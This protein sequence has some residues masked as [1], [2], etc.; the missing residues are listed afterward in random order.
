MER[1]KAAETRFKHMKDQFIE[2]AGV[3]G[4]RQQSNEDKGS[5]SK[6]SSE[7]KPKPKTAP[8]RED[9]DLEEA[10]EDTKEKSSNQIF[11]LF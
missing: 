4:E 9:V 5:T 1:L 11:W 10:D 7:T 2:Q 8:V 3:W 6:N